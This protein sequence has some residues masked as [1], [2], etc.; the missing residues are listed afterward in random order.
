MIDHIDKKHFIGKTNKGGNEL[1]IINHHN[2]PEIMEEIGRLREVSFTAAG[3]GTGNVLDIDDFDTCEKCYQQLIVYSPE[4][5]EIIGG[6]R[7]IDCS[8]VIDEL[9]AGEHAISTAHY[10][11]FSDKFIHEYL[12]K[13]LELGRSWIQPNYQPSVNPRKGLFALDNLWD[14]LGAIVVNNPEIEYFFGKVT[15]YPNYNKEARAALQFFMQQFFPDNEKLVRPIDPLFFELND[16]SFKNEI[17]DLAFKEAHKVLQKYVRERGEFIPPLINNYMQL[18]SS[19]LTFG[20]ANNNEFGKV[21][22]TG[23]LIT[24]D[25]IYPEKKERHINL[26]KN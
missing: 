8:T 18:S 25:D 14:G 26:F 4:D 9:K 6:Y 22:E 19:M 17:A 2:A 3:G 13:T 5:K 15:M 21:Q 11:N 23:I 10:F 24:I 12:P 20:T 16:E 7:F 1:Y